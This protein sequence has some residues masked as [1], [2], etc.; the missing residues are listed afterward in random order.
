MV[1]S[2]NSILEVGLVV[3]ST[4]GLIVV[5]PWWRRRDS[6]AFRLGGFLPVFLLASQL[7]YCQ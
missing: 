7:C 2:I 3:V 4:A 1:D 5:L 6:G